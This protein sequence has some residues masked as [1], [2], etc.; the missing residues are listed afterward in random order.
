MFRRTLITILLLVLPL[1]GLWFIGTGAG[2]H[3]QALL[4][5]ILLEA[6]WARSVHGHKEMRPW[7]WA[8]TW[9]VGRLSAPRL[10]V[11]RIVLAGADGSAL[12]FGPGRLF[13]STTPGAPDNTVIAGRH[14]THFRFLEALRKGD[15]LR[16]E[17]PAGAA[18]AYRVT[19]AFVAHEDDMERL[20]FCGMPVLVLVTGYPF[21]AV[22][23]GGPWRY[24][25]VALRTARLVTT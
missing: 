14:D 1:G 18:Y 8:D 4:A 22:R 13:E 6:A 7:P 20:E 21:D 10:G 5:Q 2:I 24:V 3:A 15:I 25:V 19:D 9:P 17:A 23:A 11:S 16:L 12:A